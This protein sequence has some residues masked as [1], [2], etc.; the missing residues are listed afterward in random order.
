[1]PAYENDLSQLVYELN[2]STAA[3]KPENTTS[4]DPLL[5]L[6]VARTKQKSSDRSV[7]S[8]VA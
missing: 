5:T 2:Q 3:V 6:A 7:S 8:S 4:L 1:M